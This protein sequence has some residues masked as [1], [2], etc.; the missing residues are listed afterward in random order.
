[1]KIEYY[2]I[3]H[4]L[5]FPCFFP[6]VSFTIDTEDLKIKK[7]YS[8]LNIIQRQLVYTFYGFP[9]YIVHSFHSNYSNEQHWSRAAVSGRRSGGV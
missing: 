5:P 3:D 6:T 1:M 7:I 4:T 8:S 9:P 2:T